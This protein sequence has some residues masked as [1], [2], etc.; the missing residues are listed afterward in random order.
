MSQMLQCQVQTHFKFKCKIF[1]K[2]LNDITGDSHKD[3][4]HKDFFKIPK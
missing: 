4:R 1:G 3:D 2:T